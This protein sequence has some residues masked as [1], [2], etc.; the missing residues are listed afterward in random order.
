MLDTGLCWCSIK[1]IYSN[2]FNRT[3]NRYLFQVMTSKCTIIYTS[4]GVN[5]AIVSHC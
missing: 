3:W 4:H 1:S 5:Y 2:F